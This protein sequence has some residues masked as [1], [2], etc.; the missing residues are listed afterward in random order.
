MLQL[1]AVQFLAAGNGETPSKSLYAAA[2]PRHI[3]SGR[4]SQ[5]S[6]RTI[7]ALL[8]VDSL[9]YKRVYA[10]AVATSGHTEN[11]ASYAVATEICLP[12]RCRA[13]T[14]ATRSRTS[15]FTVMSQ[16]HIAHYAH[17]NTK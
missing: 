1:S 4:I 11:T 3:A 15:A 17:D 6:P 8:H 9:L 2:R 5:K 10:S 12:C 14:A 7:P 13:T 16:Y